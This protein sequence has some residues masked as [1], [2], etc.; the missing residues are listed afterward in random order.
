MRTVSSATATGAGRR[1]R[2]VRDVIVIGAGGGGP[3]VAKELAARGLDVLVLEAGARFLE[4]EKEWSRLENDSFNPYTGY[5]RFG[6]SDRSKPAWGRELVQNSVLFQIAG[7]GGTTLH[8]YGNCPRAM[9]GVFRG[10]NRRDRGAY[11][12]AHRFPFSY[13]HLIPY[14][15]WVEH[16]L[17]VQTAAMGTKEEAFLRGARRMGLP[18]QRSKDTT[19]A[20]HRPQEN[21]ILQPR[22][23][24][25]RTKDPDKLRYPQAKGCT[26]C[27]HCING[28]FMPRGAPRNLAAKRS[29]DNSYVPMALTADAWQR[30]G[31]AATLIVDA[32]ATEI[33]TE[34]TGN[35]LA[36]RGVR[37]RNTRSGEFFE[38]EAKVVVMAAG[39]VE[40]PRLWL[41]SGLPNPNDWIG[42]GLTEHDFDVVTGVMPYYT[43]SSKGP[44][45]AAR[46][47]FPSRGVIEQSQTPPAFQAG[48]ITASDSGI[49]GLYDNGAPVGAAGSDAVGRQVGAN[50][51]RIM[52]HGVD[53]LLSVIVFTDDDV[54]AQ[55]RVTLSGSMPPDEHGAVPRIEVNRRGR[56]P[57][58]RANREFVVRKAVRLL[59]AAGATEIYRS[60]FPPL[61]LHVH[62]TMRMGE[63]ESDSVLDANAEARAVQRLFVAD[64]SALANSIG[65]PNPT[66][67]TQALATRTAEKIF[68]AYFDGEPWVR[69]ESPVVS[70]AAAV[71]RAVTERE[72]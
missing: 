48:A 31:K 24:A 60:N 67:T 28:C 42:R 4:P 11:D 7:V 63:S 65:G 17:P 59:K 68:R 25:G 38:E 30:G 44:A 2:A 32:F 72:L 23:T 49:A 13:R 56:S 52:S 37:W 5:F 40:S 15:E 64:N 20:T 18:H 70:T 58:T 71:T 29:T 27:G 1:D 51:M 12:T 55:N 57:R 43:G 22:G 8:Y 66:L 21:A 53:R 10:Y 54:E 46:C 33:L 9:P 47:D 50:L 14:Y 45:S 19:R 35:S 26:F 69:R 34:G 61:I 36:T 16:T 6:P 3:V 39:C 62:S 41:N